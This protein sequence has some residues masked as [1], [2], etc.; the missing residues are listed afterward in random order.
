[1]PKI[2]K[3][4]EDKPRPQS[5]AICVAC[6]GTGK[7][8]RGGVCTPCMGRGVPYVW[9]CPVCNREHHGFKDMLCRNEKCPGKRLKRIYK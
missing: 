2:P 7:S 8:S 5:K 4:L 3:H 1:M 9:K 6:N